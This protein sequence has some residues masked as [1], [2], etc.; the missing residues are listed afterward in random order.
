MTETPPPAPQAKDQAPPP[1][2]KARS[3]GRLWVVAGLGLGILAMLFLLQWTPTLH[4]ASPTAARV[5]PAPAAPALVLWAG[6]VPELHRVLR[7]GA[8]ASLID[9]ALLQKAAARTRW[10]PLLGSRLGR[11]VA[12]S[13][14]DD[15]LV[16]RSASGAVAVA[17]VGPIGRLAYGASRWGARLLARS[18][19]ATYGRTP[20]IRHAAGGTAIHVAMRGAYAFASTDERSLTSALALAD[21]TGGVPSFEDAAGGLLVGSASAPHVGLA[22]LAKDAPVRAVTATVEPGRLILT[23][24]FH[25]LENLRVLPGRDLLAP[26]AAL[27][28]S[29]GAF[30]SIAWPPSLLAGSSEEGRRLRDRL[31]AW[32]AETAPAPAVTL[33]AEVSGPVAIGL[34]DWLDVPGQLP[35]PKAVAVA[36]A[37]D[38]VAV[39]AATDGALRRILHPSLQRT[40]G[41]AGAAAL[42]AY[43]N[44]GR[45][46][47]LGPTLAALPK[48]LLLGSSEDAVREAL[49]A[50]G[51]LAPCLSD[52]PELAELRR[53]AGEDSLAAVGFLAGP[54]LSRLGSEVLLALASRLSPTAASDARELLVPVAKRLEAVRVVLFRVSV[55]RSGQSAQAEWQVELASTPP[56]D[57][58]RKQAQ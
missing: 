13:L 44:E 34:S 27:P 3:H 53:F 31:A 38:G 21:G 26:S 22:V 4:V 45:V 10:A 25:P 23:H 47:A 29:S 37:R 57:S 9:A 15:A 48:Q 43:H 30:A 20:G 56:S 6:R 18:R 17:R 49:A 42:V 28:K 14:S 36:V 32:L 5:M 52:R 2:L 46:G 50:A 19:A 40:E 11:L 55:E 54:E 1:V 12:V 39:S 7:T 8:W 35:F 33:T 51:G 24:R 41:R 58:G 16:V